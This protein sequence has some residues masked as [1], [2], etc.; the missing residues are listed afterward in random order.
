VTS[1]VSRLRDR[2]Q[3][4]PAHWREIDGDQ[5]RTRVLLMQE[6]LRRSALWSQALDA[7]VWLFFDIAELIDPGVRAPEDEV[8]K[9]LS[10][11]FVLRPFR[12]S[13]EHALHF[14]ALRDARIGLP[15][16][17]H[18]FTPLL[19]MYEVGGG[20]AFGHNGTV[21]VD[22]AGIVPMIREHWVAMPPRI[23]VP[24]E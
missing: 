13:A 8:G 9:A 15:G 10:G 20:F 19:A 11:A 16:L 5:H 2:L 14:E 21:D 24:G 22:G 3:N 6:F 18:P 17:P 23:R 12:T 7:S 1:H 4:A